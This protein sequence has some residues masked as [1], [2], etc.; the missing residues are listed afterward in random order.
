MWALSILATVTLG[1]LGHRNCQ[2]CWGT[3]QL[4]LEDR[5]VL[6][7][8]LILWISEEARSA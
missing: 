1:G 2:G 8:G 7:K 3:G 6:R 4:P 5:V